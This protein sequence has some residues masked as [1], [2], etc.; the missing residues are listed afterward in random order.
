MSFIIHSDGASRGNP[1][2]AGAGAVI[3]S[4]KG[5]RVADVCE[6]LGEMTNNQA[7]YHA[8]RLA[9]ERA[10]KL[11]ATDVVIRA[12]SE[13]MIKQLRGE[14]KVKNEGIRPIFRA[15]SAM[16]SKFASWKAEHVRRENNKEADRLANE[17]I[18]NHLY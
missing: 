3:F 4:S 18:D 2:H 17:A 15:I 12:D 6:Y 8:L 14:Y 9:L 7:E 5:A 16:L 1:G 10:V 11:G 13:L